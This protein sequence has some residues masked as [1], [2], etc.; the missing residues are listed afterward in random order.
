MNLR[1]GHFDTDLFVSVE[2]RECYTSSN[3]LCTCDMGD[4][5]ST[6]LNALDVASYGK[7][8]RCMHELCGDVFDM[9]K[10]F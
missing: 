8:I 4:L 6:S 3:V 9:N 10:D 5:M 1:K 7:M 2:N